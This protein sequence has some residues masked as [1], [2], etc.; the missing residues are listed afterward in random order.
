MGTCSSTGADCFALGVCDGAG[1][2]CRGDRGI[3]LTREGPSYFAQKMPFFD[4]FDSAT[5]QTNAG[6]P[7]ALDLR[8]QYYIRVDETTGGDVAFAVTIDV[9]KEANKNEDP[10]FECALA[11]LNAGGDCTRG[12]W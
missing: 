9:D 6:N 2:V 3:N 10:P 5:N 12:G 1:T 8:D 4:A 7:V 11:D